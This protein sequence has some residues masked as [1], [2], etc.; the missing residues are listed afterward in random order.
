MKNRMNICKISLIVLILILV[1]G[2]NVG[3][4]LRPEYKRGDGGGDPGVSMS[5]QP[6]TV[7]QVT[8]NKGNI[9]TTIDNYGSIGG[10]HYYG[11]PS[12][13]YPRNSGHDYIGEIKYWMGAVTASGDTL[14]AN[15]SDDFQALPMQ[16]GIR[17]DIDTS[18][19]IYLST[20]TTRYYNYT[21]EDTVGDGYENPAHGWRVWSS[22]I[23]DYVYNQTYD[24]LLST[25]EPAGPTSLQES[26][27]RFNDAASGSSLMGLEL[28]HTMLQWN[29][30]YNEN[31]IFV[32]IEITNTSDE[33]Y[34]N[35][36][37]GLYADIDVGGFDGTGENG[38]LGDLVEYDMDENLG[39]IYD[40]DGYDPGW[41]PT[42]TCGVMGTKVLKTPQDIGVTAFRSGE[43]E[44]L[45]DA[46]DIYK[47]E[48]LNS[49]Q[50]DDQTIPRDLLYIQCT[51]GINLTAGT[52]VEFVYA[53]VAGKNES[54]FRANATMAQELYDN[55]YVGPLPP[56][57]PTIS[58]RPSDRKVYM[59]WDD[60]AESA[61]DPMSGEYDFAGYKLYRSDNQG[62][63]WGIVNEENE[64]DCLTTD[65]YTIALYTVDT[66][67]DPIPHT[68]VDTGLYNGVEY[69]YC[70][71]AFDRGDTVTGVD[72][73]QSGFGVAGEA[74]NVLAVTP[75]N[76][77]AGH[78]E[79]SATVDH[80]YSGLE[81]PAD[82]E[83]VP[84]LFDESEVLG[85]DYQVV[86][87]DSPTQTL[88]HLINVTS[89]DTVLANQTRLDGEGEMYD[90]GE[91]IRVV[92]VDAE[93]EPAGFGQTGFAGVD[94]TLAL[95][96]FEGPLLVYWIGMEAYAF[97]SAQ[98]RPT[99]EFRFTDDPTL[100]V[101][102]W[103]Y[104]D[105][106]PYPLTP[107][108]FE[109]WNLT[110]NER[111]SLA[112][113]EWPIDETWSPGD[114]LAI[115]DY[116]YDPGNDLTSLAFPYY[117]GWRM[118]FDGDVYN[119]S[120]GDVLTV[121]GAPVFGPDD[122]FSFKMDGISNSS[123]SASLKNIKVV[124]NPYIAHYSAMVETGEGESVLEFQ[125]V[126]DKCTIRI[127]TLAGDLV[128]TID[129]DDGSGTARWDLMSK[130][131]IQVASGIYLFHVES[132]Y[133]EHLGRFAVIK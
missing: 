27:Y 30:C 63:T 2:L 107:V 67:G 14:V 25:Y 98:Y 91:G 125:K 132:S 52:T 80:S 53:I 62:K 60:V 99:Y 17:D 56:T 65:Y 88:W 51:R 94:T 105:A 34:T 108:P 92:V 111:V 82:G 97:G 11:L 10:Y 102:M 20:D 103:E 124:P 72:A 93:K 24:P 119:P 86:F 55:N 29:Y 76:N 8:H 41:G 89:G 71:A 113:D 95:A 66:P 4:V 47:Y 44:E 127:Y 64:N 5:P 6:I 129:H 23:E 73:L 120:D 19:V 21:P 49:A 130:D 35:F 106:T 96:S 50:V 15:T 110:T 58:I 84:I 126:P 38:R 1:Q 69:W 18:Y 7:D 45:G 90:I 131:N 100:A 128:T 117:Y 26:H 37:F 123:A 22:S 61:V 81:Q 33:D 77:P 59:H 121:E 36:V 75:R 40:Q 74:V 57:T 78:Y 118:S 133:G 48:I 122:V 109:V 28:T 70:L 101:S 68:F 43:W 46:N 85:T 39:W 104:F 54:D 32:K 42:V 112:T 83:V 114:G 12:G 116:P 115:V 31:F 16:V 79:A 87:E 3:A 13:E 9:L